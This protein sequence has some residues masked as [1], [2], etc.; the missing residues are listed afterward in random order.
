MRG[1]V[2]SLLPGDRCRIDAGND[3]VFTVRLGG[4]YGAAAPFVVH[5]F[6]V[7]GRGADRIAHVSAQTPLPSAPAV[8]L[9]GAALD[10]CVAAMA[11]MA[12]H[13]RVTMF[14]PAIRY[15][16]DLD[17]ITDDAARALMR[18][19]LSTYLPRRPPIA[20]PA[21]VCREDALRAVAARGEPMA[22][23]LTLCVY[24]EGVAPAVDFFCQ[25]AAVYCPGEDYA[26]ARVLLL[27]EGVPRGPFLL[28]RTVV[29][30]RSRSSNE[31]CEKHEEARRDDDGAG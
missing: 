31:P 9:P 8:L 28:G 4:L 13:L 18:A 19:M 14:P 26:W 11:S 5:E 12:R 20:W 30:Y 10:L 3:G 1:I 16:E 24:A 29:R 25:A 27:E 21:A 7:E 22:A 6:A 15:V 2:L 23:R 17:G